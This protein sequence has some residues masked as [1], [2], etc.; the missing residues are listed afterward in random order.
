MLSIASRHIFRGKIA[1]GRQSFQLIVVSGAALSLLAAACGTS[2]VKA[3]VATSSTQAATKRVSGSV[4][5]YAALT[6]AND[7]EITKAFTKYYR[8]IG[9]CCVW[10]SKG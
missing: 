8:A 6:D 2:V 9:K 4:T 1:K 3:S 5:V 7:A 10:P